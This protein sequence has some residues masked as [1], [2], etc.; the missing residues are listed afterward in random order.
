MYEALILIPGR[1]PCTSGIKDN[2]AW[3]TVGETTSRLYHVSPLW[4][5]SRVFHENTMAY[6]IKCCRQIQKDKNWDSTW[7]SS[8]EQVCLW[9]HQDL[10]PVHMNPALIGL[11]RRETKAYITSARRSNFI[12]GWDVVWL[13][14]SS[15]IW[16]FRGFSIRYANW[17]CC[18]MFCWNF[19][20]CFISWFRRFMREVL[21]ICISELLSLELGQMKDGRDMH[22]LGQHTVAQCTLDFLFPHELD[23]LF[24]SQKTIQGLEGKSEIYVYQWG[25]VLFSIKISRTDNLEIWWYTFDM[26]T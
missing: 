14:L 20:L 23:I 24:F 13:F 15:Q 16:Q 10:L 26:L 8:T 25:F 7:I 1:T 18:S 22:T 9:F 3:Y 21:H 17:Y 5:F 2:A 12:L 4:S 6:C 19:Q 11:F